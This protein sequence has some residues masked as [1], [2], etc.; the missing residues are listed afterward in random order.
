[1]KGSVHMLDVSSANEETMTAKE[2]AALFGKSITTIYNWRDK[3]LIH[4]IYSCPTNRGE[5]YSKTEILSLYKSG[6]RN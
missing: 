2:V 1:M 6:F 3:K 4:P 5:I